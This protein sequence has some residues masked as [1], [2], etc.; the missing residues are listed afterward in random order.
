MSIQQWSDQVFVVDLADDPLFSD[1]MGT[2]LDSLQAEGDRHVLL[3]FSGVSFINSSNL[4]ALLRLRKHQRDRARRLILCGLHKD[5]H[6]VFA[7]TALEAMF[8]FAGQVAIALAALQLGPR[9]DKEA[10]S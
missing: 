2:L 9:P 10:R 6:S 7:I 3:D 8:E 4:A 1:D 5:V